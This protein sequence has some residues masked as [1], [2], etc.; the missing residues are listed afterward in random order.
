MKLAELNQRAEAGLKF[1]KEKPLATFRPKEYV[2]DQMATF[3]ALGMQTQ[4]AL[5]HQANKED[6]LKEAGFYKISNQEIIK[7]LTGKIRTN[8]LFER[9]RSSN[10]QFIVI[11]YI[12]FMPMIKQRILEFGTLDR[13]LVSM[14]F[15]IAL[16][17]KEIKEQNIFDEFICFAPPG[18]FTV[19]KREPVLLHYDPIIVGMINSDQYFIAQW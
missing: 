18:S 3:R 19:T 8:V 6:W 12:P 16:R 5:I 10:E 4:V 9:V 14:P 17:I 15:G 2:E 7:K 13:L 11:N 1:V